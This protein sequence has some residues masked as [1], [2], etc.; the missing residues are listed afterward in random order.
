[1]TRY[2][3]ILAAI[4]A[5]ALIGWLLAR[6]KP[7]HADEVLVDATQKAAWWR[8]VIPWIA[9]FAVLMAGLFLL[10]DYERAPK[11]SAYQPAV[12]EG[13]QINPGRFEQEEAEGASNGG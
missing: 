5:G 1:M 12:I 6:P 10:A 11:E 7:P 9:G 3:I 13:D 2:L 8:Q 4:L